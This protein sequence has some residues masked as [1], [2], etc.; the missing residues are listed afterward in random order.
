[1]LTPNQLNNIPQSFVDLYSELETFILQDIA[2]R[3]K[4]AGNITSTAEYQLQQA[5]LYNIKNVESKIA[6]ILKLSQKQVDELFPQIAEASLDQEARI[7][8]KAGYKPPGLKESQALRDYLK[9]A[10]KNTKGDIENITQSLGFAEVQNGHVVYNN[11]A[12][13]YQKEL[14]LANFKVL[15]GTSDY[16]SAIKQAIRKI[17]ESGVRNVN[18][19]SGYSINIDSAAR[20]AVLTSVQQMSQQMTDENARKIINNEDDIYYEVSAHEGARHTGTGIENHKEW[21]GKVYKLK[22]S[23]KDYPNLKETTGLGDIRGLKGA[24]CRHSYS[25]FIIGASVRTYTDEQLKNI[26]PPPFKYKDKE[27]TYYE[28]TQYQRQIENEI[29]KLKREQLMYKE[30]GL[31]EEFKATKS[32]IN[33]LRKEYKDFS[34]VANISEKKNRLTI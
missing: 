5:K 11:I 7:Y 24:G 33:I 14:N 26:D 30:T 6:E 20:K 3:I 4:K 17:A 9:A 21:Q 23:T 8:K 18:Y 13:F 15:S 22:G 10:I 27:Y 29:R 12:K 28:A 16:N 2:R 32:K 34:S 19:D 1:M 31:E 25:I